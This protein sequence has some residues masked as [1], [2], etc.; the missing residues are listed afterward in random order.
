MPESFRTY[1]EAKANTFMYNAAVPSFMLDKL[2]LN[3]Y[4]CDAGAVYEV[5]KQ[6]NVEYEF[7][8]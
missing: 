2:K 7:A 8:L 1:Q 5:Q 6:F 4:E 3:L